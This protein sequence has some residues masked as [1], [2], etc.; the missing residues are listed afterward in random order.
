MKRVPFLGKLM[1]MGV[2]PLAVLGIVVG[3]LSFAQADRVVKQSE[4]RVLSD[5]I[6]RIDI[7]LN[8]KA[9]QLSGFVQT[10]AGSEP[11][12]Q[13]LTGERNGAFDAGTIEEFCRNVFG[14]FSEVRSV[15]VIMG[16]GA[17][18][19][20]RG[21]G[22]APDAERLDSLY[23]RAESHPGKVDWSGLT[24]GLYDP[25]A[26]CILLSE[27]LFDAADNLRGLIVLELDPRLF[28]NMILTK[29]K[30][31]GYQTTFLTDQAGKV[32]CSDNAVHDAWL[33]KA[34]EAYRAG[35]RKAAVSA[36]GQDYYL[37]AQYNGLT[38]WVTYTIIPEEGLFPGA[39]SLRRYIVFLVL[40]ATAM[41]FLFLLLLSSAIV[42]PLERLKN[43]MKQV[44]NRNFDLQ[45]ENDRSD[46]IGDLTET[47]NYMVNR[48]NTL[49]NQVYQ[50]RIAQKNAEIEA[51]QAQINPHFLYNT[52]DSVNWMLIGRGEM[53]ISAV[54][55]ALGKLMQYSMDTATSMVTLEVECAN[56]HDYLMVQK[57]RLEERLEFRLEL[58]EGLGSFPVPKLILQPLVENAIKY[59]IEPS[60]R[61]GTVLVR[62]FRQGG[63]VHLLVK[64]DGRGMGPEQLARYRA[65]L[66]SGEGG[67]STSIGVRNV[68]RRLQLHFNDR[69]G[70]TVTSS[71]GDGM[72]IEITIPENREE[73][74]CIS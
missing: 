9:R 32:I 48:I 54:V 21:T 38:N 71:P 70:F 4:K 13:M 64:D 45:L 7:S 55:V 18:Y 56:V 11:V 69:C 31:L 28:G 2:F 5:T 35:E 65:L 6:N 66:A 15:S 57:N 26:S 16:R 60:Q 40:I 22:A 37:C 3:V 34:L 33:Q 72:S 10:A 29:Q 36:N 59:G 12:A 58:E 20:S 67:G 50:E 43:G 14:S 42:K 52:L 39:P 53:D 1:I 47:F 17:V 51:L 41:A 19:T 23:E 62:A 44:Q 74:P 27:G 8:V 46:E 49:V 68:A 24:Q 30:I 25:D 73:T 61:R 63:R